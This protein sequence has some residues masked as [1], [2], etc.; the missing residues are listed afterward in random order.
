[1]TDTQD[2][3]MQKKSD[4][5][6]YY[7]MAQEAFQA[8]DVDQALKISNN[9]LRE[10]KLQKNCEWIDKF[11]IFNSNVSQ[12]NSLN[13]SIKRESLTIIDG[14]GLKVAEKL[15]EI[16][17]SSIS[18]L[19][20][21][22]PKK[23]TQ[24]NGIGIV[25][26]QKFIENAKQHVRLKKLNDFP[27]KSNIRINLDNTK[28]SK[29]GEGS[30]RWFERK[31]EKP[32]TE[33]WYAPQ[34]DT[35]DI[36]PLENSLENFERYDDNLE[37][38]DY[39]EIDN[40]GASISNF[41]VSE[42]KIEKNNPEL[43]QE[44][45]INN[46]LVVPPE[47]LRQS[48]L[49]VQEQDTISSESLNS[50]QLQEIYLETAKELE[51]SEF[52]I[53]KKSP[54]LRTIFTGIDLLAV[55][56]IRVKEFLELILIIPIK[57]SSLNGSII[58]SG[59]AIK[60]RSI[61]NYTEQNFRLERLSQSYLKAFKN[62]QD[63]LLE[64]MLNEGRFFRYLSKYLNINLFLEKT[65][66]H[67]K[68]FFRSGPL[69]YKILIEPLLIHRNNVGFA[70]KLVPFAYQKQLNIHILSLSQ[71]QDFLQYIDQKHFL[72]E[73]YSEQKNALDLHCKAS[74]KFIKD[75]RKYS[76]PFMLY[77]FFFLLV[78]LFQAYS[79]LSF[80]INLGYGVISFYIVL[81]AYIYL[82]LYKQKSELQYEFATPYYQKKL[83]FDETNLILINEELSTRFMEQFVFECVEKDN[84]FNIIN[85]I[86]QKNAENFLRNKLSKRKIEG[87][88][89]FESNE[90]LQSMNSKENRL[91]NKL[92]E[93]Y[94]S[95]LED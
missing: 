50:S 61:G 64:D 16:G 10:A 88:E 41:N 78:L 75:L 39:E 47:L 76:T 68:L 12:Q 82:R 45:E 33:E 46:F 4:L 27:E 60:Y 95:F 8:N 54:E 5:K 77:G 55:K 9:G 40:N 11:D 25:K 71:L 26:A 63:V 65:F 1:M 18:E 23:I 48:N 87:L 56:L 72:I 91:K 44:S 22:S 30:H 38:F 86:E 53:I 73:T 80:L 6:F 7:K 81:I 66:T 29:S 13:P 42:K 62:I 28:E 34:I 24:I 57:I 85:K 3:L 90:N 14:I 70:E 84:D 52:V 20:Y 2:G 32:E 74:N 17:I 67:K 37:E 51:L 58:V 31:F 15:A 36:K 94:S 35:S 83:D 93:K 19:A 89:L 79:V 49:K 92:V 43:S 59:N 69:Q 21:S